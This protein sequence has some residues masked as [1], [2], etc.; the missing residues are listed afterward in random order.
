MPHKLI[1]DKTNIIGND[2]N[3]FVYRFP[4]SVAFPN[5]ELALASVDMYYAWYNVSALL[6]NNTFSYVWTDGTVNTVVLEDGLYEISTINERLQFAFIANGHYLVDS[7]GNNI[8]YINIS[9]NTTRYA[10]QID[11]FQFPN[12]L[13]AGYTNP[14]AVG[15]PP[16]NQITMT[17]PTKFNELLGFAAGFTTTAP[18]GTNLSFLSSVAPNIQPNNVLYVSVS[19]ID[20]KYGSPSGL[21]HRIVPNTTFGSLITENPEFSFQ[22]LHSGTY[23][24]LQIQI[25]GTDKSPIKIIDP[26]IVI[27][28]LIKNKEQSVYA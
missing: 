19:N 8:Y 5:H 3:T 16:A 10:T 6:G 23:N 28:F 4:S 18:T 20:N 21:V 17:M 2:N 22:P 12:A 27:T 1:V 11:I 9:A 14:A 26:N 24:Q 15:F 25:L 7:G 13:P